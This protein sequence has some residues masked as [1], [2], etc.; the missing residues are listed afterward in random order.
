MKGVVATF[1]FVT[2]GEGVL[3]RGGEQATAVLD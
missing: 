3:H 2:G 1:H